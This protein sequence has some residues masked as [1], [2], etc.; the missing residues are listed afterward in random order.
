MQPAGHRTFKLKHARLLADRLQPWRLDRPDSRAVNPVPGMICEDE[1]LFLHWI[2]KHASGAGQVV[3]LGP[4]AGGSTHSLCSGLALNPAAARSKVRVHSYDLW[5]LFPGWEAFFP[6]EQLKLGDDLRPLFRRNLRAFGD[7]VVEHP[8]DLCAHR[9]HG[10]PIEILFIDA[11]KAAHLWAHIL[12]TFLPHCI[13]GRALIVHQDW[14][15]AECPWIH[16]TT[17]RLSD[18]L[19]P[20]DSPDGGT[21]AFLVTR[22]IPPALLKESAD[23]FLAQP[24]PDAAERFARAASWMDGWYA[25]N[26]ML[27]EAHYLAMRGCANESL[28]ILDRVLAHPDS[29]LP[30]VQYDVEL[31]RSALERKTPAAPPPGH[32]GLLGRIARRIARTAG[33]TMK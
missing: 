3:D 1:S 15:C 13:P 17:A 12:R 20:V 7:V 8:G 16:L 24:R 28:A 14:V 29:S 31:V 4:L 19:I 32:R 18:Y 5:R 33:V 10:E 25:L 30:Q 22:A 27:A 26:V 21:V 11:A 2:A 9:W 23:G 6:G